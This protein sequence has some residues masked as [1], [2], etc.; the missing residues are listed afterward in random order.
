MTGM[1]TRWPQHIGL[2]VLHRL[3]RSDRLT[4]LHAHHRIGQRILPQPVGPPD[5]FGP[6]HEGANVDLRG[7][8]MIVGRVSARSRPGSFASGG[9]HCRRGRMRHPDSTSSGCADV[10]PISQPPR[11]ST[12]IWRRLTA[13][14]ILTEGEVRGN[15]HG[16]GEDEGIARRAYAFWLAEGQPDGRQEEHWQRAARE[17]E[18]AESANGAVK[19]TKRRKKR[20]T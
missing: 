14:L 2:L 17:I 9:G 7:V 12:A 6:S 15:D 19:R 1:T 4:E 8:A 16:Y 13:E 18:A 10:S 3:D 20:K 5:H 11:P